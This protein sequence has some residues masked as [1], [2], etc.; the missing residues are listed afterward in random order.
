MTGNRDVD[1][2]KSGA[3]VSADN[4]VDQKSSAECGEDPI[5]GTTE[6]IYID[7]AKEAAAFR[8]FDLYVLPV[9][10]IFLVLS[11]LDR[12][13]VGGLLIW[14]SVAELTFCYHS[15]VMLAC[16]ASMKR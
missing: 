7:P 5:A 4:K 8:K 6:L 16:S 11:S 13:N 10:V 12:N 2:E 1:L 3:I 15:L 9:S 14:I